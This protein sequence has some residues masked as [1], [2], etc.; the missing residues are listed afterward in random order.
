MSTRRDQM[1]AI[2]LAAIY[3]WTSD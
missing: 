1:S 2:I 3:T